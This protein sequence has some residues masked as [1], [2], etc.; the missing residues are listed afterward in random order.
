MELGDYGGGPLTQPPASD[1]AAFDH[2]PADACHPSPLRDERN[3]IRPVG[4][5]CD[6]GA[7]ELGGVVDIILISL[8]ESGY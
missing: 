5:G 1:S 2:I 4:E 6:S 8:F 3:A 7:V